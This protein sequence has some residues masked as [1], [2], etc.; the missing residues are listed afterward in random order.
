MFVLVL[1]IMNKIRDDECSA[2]FKKLTIDFFSTNFLELCSLLSD[3]LLYL[4]IDE[5]T[6]KRC[7]N[8]H[9]YHMNLTM[10]QRAWLN[11][12][13]LDD[14]ST[15]LRWHRAKGLKLKINYAC[16][17]KTFLMTLI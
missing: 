1:S 9:L 12:V 8:T 15:T 11:V 7:E 3:V 4:I 10:S 6:T 13:T 14:I 16:D 5:D 2:H 17:R